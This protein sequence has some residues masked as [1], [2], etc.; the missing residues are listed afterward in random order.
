[1][2]IMGRMACD[3]GQMISWDEA[4]HSSLELAPGLDQFTLDSKAPV[5]ADEQGRFPVAVPGRTKSL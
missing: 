3:S 1:V 4:L 5:Q 2:A